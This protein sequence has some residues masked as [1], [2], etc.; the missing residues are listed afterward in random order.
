MVELIW[1]Q[2]LSRDIYNTK[3]LIHTLLLNLITYVC[4]VKVLQILDKAM[5]SKINQ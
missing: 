4:S 3:C 2:S 5:L 1:K